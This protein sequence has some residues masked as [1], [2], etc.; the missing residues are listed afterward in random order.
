MYRLGPWSVDLPIVRLRCAHS[1]EV[2]A[3]Q[4]SCGQGNSSLISKWDIVRGIDK[5]WY[6]ITSNWYSAKKVRLC[7]ST[8]TNWRQRVS[9]SEALEAAGSGSANPPILANYTISVID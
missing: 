7:D 5:M 4:V 8:R 2:E 1:E 6:H 9:R 3:V